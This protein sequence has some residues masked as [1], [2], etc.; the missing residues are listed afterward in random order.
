MKKL[1]VMFVLFAAILFLMVGCGGGTSSDNDVGI[2]G[3]LYNGGLVWLNWTDTIAGGSGGL[4]DGAINKDFVR[5]KA[6]HGWDAKGFNGGYVRRTASGTRPNPTAGTDLTAAIGSVVTDDVW[7]T[8][9]RTFTLEDTTM[10]A[11]DQAEGLTDQQVADVEA[12]LNNGPK[13]V[14]FATLDI[15][16]DP[17]TYTFTSPDITNGATLFAASCSSC[18]PTVDTAGVGTALGPYFAKDGKYSEGFHKV[19]YGAGGDSVMTRT[20]MGDLTGQQAADIL[21][22]IQNSLMAAAGGLGWLNWTDTIAGGSGA[23]PAGAVNKDFVRCK[24]CHG[25]DAKGSNGGYVRRTATGTRPNPT[26]GTDLTAAIGSVAADDVWHTAGR[27]FT[28]EDTT[29]PAFDQADGLTATQ[30]ANIVAFLNNGPKIGDYATLDTATN[31][32][33]YTFP[34]SRK[35]GAAA[36]ASGATLYAASCAGCHSAVD[37]VVGG[38]AATPLSPYFVKDGKYSEGFHKAYYGAGG[39]STMTR[40]A[41]GNLTGQQV[42][43]ILEYIQAVIAGNVIPI[44]DEFAGGLVW[45]NWTL[46]R[47]GGSGA[48][49]AGA[50]NA[51]FV[52]C[53]A[54]HGWDAMGLNG[55]YVRRTATGTRPN[56]TAGTDLTASLGSVVAG[57]VWHT[58]GRAFTIEDTTMPAFDQAGG[59]TAT[60][61]DN[62]A[63]F[64]N[65]GEKISDFAT[66]NTATNPVTYTFTA[67]NIANGATLYGTNCAGCHGALGGAGGLGKELSA[68]FEGDGKYSEGFHKMIY[69]DGGALMTSAAAG[70]LAGQ[71]AT[72]IL[73]HIQDYIANNP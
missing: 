61:V 62:V 70:S 14:D 27:A 8:A 67:P 49:P 9:G 28:T 1:L 43:N 5:C 50:T 30:V 53:K 3:D 45:L 66:L 19:V 26:A 29:M 56:P 72:D 7:Y 25:W 16:T 58:T 71:E 60:Q 34:A 12:F 21:A 63:T 57:D 4:P 51:D 47:A 52:R 35:R 23:L 2:T 31:P 6:C 44:G 22:Y 42:A 39:A 68:Y 20:A 37:D 32:V 55:G 41:I 69:G 24:A 40:E 46:T 36:V 48:L 73:A 65:T 33:T 10:P 54:C 17:V 38:V 13:I 15:A 59:L 64:L 18:H 11:F